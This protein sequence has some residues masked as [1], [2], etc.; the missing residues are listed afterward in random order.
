MTCLNLS[1]VPCIKYKNSDK[2]K[3]LFKKKIL[4]KNKS[5]LDLK[6]DKENCFL[7]LKESSNLFDS[8]EFLQVP[9]GI[10]KECLKKNA[11]DW[12]FRCVKEA[13]QYKENYMITLTYDND[14]LPF[15]GSLVKD[16]ISKFNKKLKTYLSRLNLPSDFRFFGCGEYGSQFGRPHYHII[17]FNLQ[18]SKLS[19]LLGLRY[20][21]KSSK[22]FPIYSCKFLDDTWSK[23]IVKVSECDIGSCAYVAHYVDKKK[24]FTKGQK[25]FFYN[26][27]GLVPDFC[28]MSRNPGIG[29]CFIE[30]VDNNF[31]KGFFNAYLNGQCYAIPKFYINKLKDYGLTSYDIYKDNLLSNRFNI[32]SYFLDI[33]KGFSLNYNLSNNKGRCF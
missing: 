24:C 26:N 9:C 15:N 21:G 32:D 30:D 5:D 17:Y 25:E 19:E 10:C 6:I 14:N 29:S 2:K 20:Y 7:E 4:V 28:V 31:L 22:G 13:S 23:G 3:M 1:Y 11:R 18:L 16:E 12:A 33:E 8:V 27:T